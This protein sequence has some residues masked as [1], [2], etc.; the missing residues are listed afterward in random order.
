M[1]QY[2]QLIACYWLTPSHVLRVGN[3]VHYNT[4]YDND[5]LMCEI[6]H[7]VWGI[8]VSTYLFARTICLFVDDQQ[9]SK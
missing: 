5:Y 3:Y 8:R 9:V 1:K 4:Q 7:E 6:I 2:I